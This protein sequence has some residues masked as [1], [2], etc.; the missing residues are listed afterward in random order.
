MFGMHIA[1]K[2]IMGVEKGVLQY[3]LFIIS[4]ILLFELRDYAIISV[5][6]SIVKYQMLYKK[7]L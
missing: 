5:L 6:G 4:V 2:I 7:I 1:I 3:I